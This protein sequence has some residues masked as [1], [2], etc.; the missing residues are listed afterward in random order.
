MVSV[1]TMPINDVTGMWPRSVSP[2]IAV[3]CL[4]NKE[5]KALLN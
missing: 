1:C 4:C 2:G 3:V 5:I